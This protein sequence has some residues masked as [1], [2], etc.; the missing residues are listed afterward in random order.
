MAGLF[1]GRFNMENIGICITF[2][3]IFDHMFLI[4]DM[5]HDLK[6]IANSGIKAVELSIRDTNDIDSESLIYNLKKNRLK[7][8]T[9]ATGLIRKIDSITLMDKKPNREIVIE[10]IVKMMDLLNKAGSKEKYILIGFVKGEL[11]EGNNWEQMKLLK[12]SLLELVGLAKERDVKILL[13]IINRGDTNFLNTIS[14]GADFISQFENQNIK[15]V[16]DTYHMSLDEKDISASIIRGREYIEC[17][18]LSDDN[19]LNP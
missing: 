9:I 1:H 14:E 10:R 3:K 15:L 4:E 13:E 19:R 11:R 5:E 2:S 18:H 16:I 12:G 7:L 17:I 8:V 6:E